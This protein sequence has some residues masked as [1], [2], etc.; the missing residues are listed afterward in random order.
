MDDGSA[1]A[2]AL[3]CSYNVL[4]RRRVKPGRK[5]FLDNASARKFTANIASQIAILIV[6]QNPK[7][8]PYLAVFIT[9]KIWMG[10]TQPYHFFP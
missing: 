6:I 3:A 7:S 8:Q 9:V 5:K 2:V 10:A 4:I 1:S